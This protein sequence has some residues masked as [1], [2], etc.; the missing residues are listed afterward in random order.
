MTTIETL[1]ELFEPTFKAVAD[2]DID[3]EIKRNMLFTLYTFACAIEPTYVAAPSRV[4]FEFG[5]C[6]LIEKEQHPLFETHKKDFESKLSVNPIG[7]G[8]W[9]ERDGKTF[10]KFDA[11]SDLFFKL[12]QSLAK[13]DRKPPQALELFPLVL[14][15]C[16]LST[17]LRPLWY[18]YFFYLA[19]TVQVGDL[20]TLEKLRALICNEDSFEKGME[21]MGS[22]LI[23]DEAELDGDNLLSEWYAPFI[24]Y[25][26]SNVARMLHERALKGDYGYVRNY[27]EAIKYTVPQKA[28]IELN[29]GARCSLAAKDRDATV[30][31]DIVRD[32][33]EALELFDSEPIKRYL[34]L[35]ELICG[36]TKKAGDALKILNDI[37][38][39]S[40]PED[41]E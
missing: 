11:G 13:S 20:D 29:I 34:V 3:Y 23:G 26:R 39:K 1:D 5:C 25:R 40:A 16:H 17:A 14:G 30:L 6:F 41:E 10:I 22:T 33:K 37:A 32:C 8:R 38:I 24:A 19:A 28:I 36:D 35:T 4:L 27:T 12:N 18:V 21:L 2:A 7:G 9:Y 31:K 15:L